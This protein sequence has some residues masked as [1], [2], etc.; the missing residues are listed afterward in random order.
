MPTFS[1][2]LIVKCQEPIQ[3]SAKNTLSGKRISGYQRVGGGRLLNVDNSVTQSAS[4]AS[5]WP[6]A[7]QLVS[8]ANNVERIR[9][10]QLADFKKYNCQSE[11]N[12]CLPN[13]EHARSKRS[14]IPPP[15][16]ISLYSSLLLFKLPAWLV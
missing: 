7:M 6:N 1:L 12:T 15:N 13:I 4:P 10:I 2:L 3:N 9:E 11:R 8:S 5:C 16:S 14:K